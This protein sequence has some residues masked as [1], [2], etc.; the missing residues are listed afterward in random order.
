SLGK[1]AIPD[2]PSSRIPLFSSC[3][4]PSLHV[5]P[6]RLAQFLPVVRPISPL[7]SFFSFPFSRP[8][9]VGN[10]TPSEFNFGA[11][12]VATRTRPAHLGYAILLCAGSS[13]M[14]EATSASAAID[15]Y[16]ARENPSLV[17]V[18]DALRALV[19]KTVPAAR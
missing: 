5:F 2:G 3:S 9:R 13:S 4:R 15:L 8:G 16:V 12:L 7:P 19:K 11:E 6:L 18:M 1:P 10:L 14:N 17:H